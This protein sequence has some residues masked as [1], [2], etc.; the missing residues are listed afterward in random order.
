MDQ[1]NQNIN[2]HRKDV[3]RQRI[4]QADQHFTTKNKKT[5]YNTDNHNTDH[6]WKTRSKLQFNDTIIP[7]TNVIINI[8]NELKNII[9]T[10]YKHDTIKHEFQSNFSINN[11]LC[12][13]TQNSITMLL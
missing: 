12:R 5:N 9:L 3:N 4:P 1:I 6:I 13:L 7:A 11:A 10:H 8:K 2:N